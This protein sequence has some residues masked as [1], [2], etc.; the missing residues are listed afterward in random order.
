MRKTLR[1]FAATLTGVTLAVSLLVAQSET[2]VVVAPA[3][4]RIMPD[5]SRVPL[6]TLSPG[7]EV[8]LEENA[9]EWYRV[10]FRDLHWGRRVGYVRAEQVDVGK[11]AAESPRIVQVSD[12]ASPVA[13]SEPARGADHPAGLAGSGISK[14]AIS[15]SIAI[16]RKQH[17]RTQG[18]ALTDSARQFPVAFAGGDRTGMAMGT[19]VRLRL[20]TPLAWIRQLAG[21]AKREHRKFGMDDVSGEASEPVLRVIVNVSASN[22]GAGSRTPA[23][24]EIVL[25]DPKSGRVVQPTSKQPIQRNPA[26]A[27]REAA[28]F[29]GWLVKFP[30]DA[31][32]AMHG[33]AENREFVVMVT[34]SSRETREFPVTKHDLDKLPGIR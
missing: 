1:R 31:I 18:L 12:I 33:A 16:G 9:G 20:Y 4:V 34:S 21:E 11:K 17:D 2:A 15:E 13:E 26:S 29:E 30:M 19:P 28:G 23:V 27:P 24:Q 25:R 22:G 5:A 6:T 32:R 7:T 10:S 3:P 14:R 8:R